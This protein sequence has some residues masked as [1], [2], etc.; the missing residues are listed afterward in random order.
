[1][2]LC[3]LVPSQEYLEQAGVRIRYRRIAAALNRHGTELVLR[4]IDDVRLPELAENDVYLFSKIPDARSITLA[5]ELRAAGRLIGADLFD[6]YFSQHDD[7]RFVIQRQ[8]L[9]TIAPLLNFFLCSTARMAD[10]LK[11]ESPSASVIQMNDP[12]ARFDEAA[13]ANSI[14]HKLVRTREERIIRVAW[15]GMGDNPHFD[16]GLRDLSGFGSALR[17]LE[18]HDFR[19]ELEVMTN[20]RALTADGLE[21]LR[22]LGVRYTISEWSADA[23]AGL[24]GRSLVAF[25]PVNSQPFSIAKSLNRAV[26]AFSHGTQI[27]SPGYPLYEAL[28]RF[29]YTDPSQ[30]VRSI[31]QGSL[32]VRRQTL[33]ALAGTLDRIANPEIEAES[34][35]TALSKL[36]G[37]HKPVKRKEQLVALLHGVKTTAVAHK[38]AQRLRHLSIATPFMSQNLK[39][40]IKFHVNRA[41]MAL[42]A[43]LS[44]RAQRRL[45]PEAVKRLMPNDD[46]DRP[47]SIIFKFDDLVTRQLL[48]TSHAGTTNILATYSTV[49]T[50]CEA[51]ILL[52]FPKCTVVVSE[53]QPPLC[54]SKILPTVGFM[55]PARRIAVIANGPIPSLAISFLRP[56]EVLADER[57]V[58]VGAIYGTD[59]KNKEIPRKDAK[60][61]NYYRQRLESIKPEVIIFCRYSGPFSQDIVAYAAEKN[62]PIIYHL[63]DDLL[64]I[65]LEIG[66]EKHAY[67]MA[68]ERIGSIKTL[69]SAAQVIY[70]S[71]PALKTRM[72]EHGYNDRLIHG[73]IYCAARVRR[74]PTR[75]KPVRIGYMGGGEH[76]ADLSLAVPAIRH[77]LEHHDNVRFEL[78][79]AFQLPE[80]LEGLDDR[81][82]LIPPIPVYED[83]LRAFARMN[84]DIGLCPLATTRFNAV[85]ANTKWVEY[86]AVGTAVIA[87]TGTVYDACCADDCGILAGNTAEWIAALET[88]ITDA[89][90]CRDQ[91]L[92]AQRKLLDHYSE[93]ALL[94]QVIDIVNMV[95]PAPSLPNGTPPA[96]SK[97][98]KRPADRGTATVT[99]K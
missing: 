54:R 71:T 3:V 22:R 31:E 77:I 32:L 57:L 68:P 42:E 67:H 78:F 63:D 74:E 25:I 48:A 35:V 34:L 50:A 73:D 91:V 29:V 97:S 70:C 21:Q 96:I 99:S 37:R 7:S 18:T 33:P 1:M 17:Q 56:L 59:L 49:M 45:A 26:T 81:I 53:L 62:I 19:V 90:A 15:F 30:L 10:V 65:P 86:T 46:A 98:K 9:R 55:E 14:E 80:G 72:V 82:T 88:L 75:S 39:F 5:H 6:D 79:G 8:W 38:L 92:R 60:T 20:R 52:L 24:L 61:F 93:P 11:Q 64:D 58:Q 36:L 16:I 83:F 84:W 43:N 51:A 89:Q 4:L 13:L 41:T 76:A 23:E 12:F 95:L 94:R 66:A 44:E 87:S 2:K 85:K 47:Q 27:L 28:D 69:L 40:D